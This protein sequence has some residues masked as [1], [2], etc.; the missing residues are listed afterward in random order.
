MS[1]LFLDP[2]AFWFS[3]VSTTCRPSVPSTYL[4]FSL[5]VLEGI[6]PPTVPTLS[7]LESASSASFCSCFLLLL[8]QRK[9]SAPMMATSATSPSA[10]PTAPP[11]P[12]PLATFFDVWL[13]DSALGGAVGV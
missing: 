8:K 12:S 3:Q 4:E 6:G 5:I 9:P 2:G 7:L 10:N 11:T 13:A 1:L